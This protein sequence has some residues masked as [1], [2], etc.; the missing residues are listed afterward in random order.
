MRKR[1]LLVLIGIAA[2]I[3]CY[4]WLMYP[5]AAGPP[6]V[7]EW[8]RHFGGGLG[9]A[10]VMVDPSENL[11]IVRDAEYV[12]SA[13]TGYMRERKAFATKYSPG[14]ELL[15]TTQLKTGD[16]RLPSMGP[17]GCVYLPPGDFTIGSLSGK[18]V[19]R[20]MPDGSV[21][22]A[23]PL[24]REVQ[25]TR[26]LVDRFGSYFLQTWDYPRSYLCKFDPSGNRKF[27]V[28]DVRTSDPTGWDGQQMASDGSG[29][30]ICF[31]TEHFSSADTI[32]PRMS[33]VTRF[34]GTGNRLWTV[35]KFSHEDGPDQFCA[36]SKGNSYVGGSVEYQ[37]PS[38]N[39]SGS[40]F[41]RIIEKIRNWLAGRRYR[42]S[43][44]RDYYI[45]KYDVRGRR[46]WSL[47]PRTPDEDY[48][49]GMTA[50]NNGNLY[51]TVAVRKGSVE[52]YSLSK[53]SPQ[54][55]L[56]WHKVLEPPGSI[57]TGS[58]G[59]IY[60]LRS[61]VN[62]LTPGNEETVITKLTER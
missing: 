60:L 24:D 9:G 37:A 6:P 17:D 51:A 48:I 14:G 56:M 46:L 40:I 1:R 13:A 62:P 35:D 5:P 39:G 31:K 25:Y 23:P 12:S 2:A 41:S 22:D 38:Y 59:H 8:T 16:V 20:I 61:Y 55:R 43:G 57:I 33:L 44:G 58:K 29:G 21:R 32:Y 52:S 4:C 30:I 10:R 26:F 34:D 36:D 53:Y 11:Y 42:A 50:D 28:D 54:G 49:G 47:E 45:E 15:W 3:A 18:Q 7:E 27:E 19:T